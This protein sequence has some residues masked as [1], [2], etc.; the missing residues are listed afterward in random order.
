MAT[1]FLAPTYARKVFPCFDEPAVK[2]YFVVTL[3]RK[4]QMVTLSK[5]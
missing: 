1:S 2:S 3:V 4:P 5:I